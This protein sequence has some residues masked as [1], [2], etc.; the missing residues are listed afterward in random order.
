MK[1]LKVPHSQDP[2]SVTN[3]NGASQIVLVCEHASNFIPEK[4]EN[5]GLQGAALTSHIAWDPGAMKV[6]VVL[7]Q[8][9]DA[10]VVSSNVSRLVYDC[11]RPPSA[12]D[13][14]PAKSETMDVPGNQGLSAADRAT[15]AQDYYE[16]FQAKLRQVIGAR[17]N[18]VIVT[19]HSFTPIY[20]GTHR[21]VEIGI[22]HDDDDRLAL[23]MMNTAPVHT[24]ASVEL[25][26][27]YGQNDGVTHTLIEHG[28]KDGH[29]NV[30]I[31]IRNDL[32]Q[33][34]ASH[35]EMGQTLAGWVSQSLMQLQA[36]DLAQC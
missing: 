8:L 4:F 7:S 34:S 31:E 29:L 26:E 32:L 28:I 19:L 5:L 9:L 27:P 35:Q 18:P 10:P 1:H 11:N 20:H 30:M 3:P 21:A 23:E 2:V 16:P 14:M 17:A 6:A 36:E 25:N 33:T 13:A 15:R 24:S 22:L 12:K